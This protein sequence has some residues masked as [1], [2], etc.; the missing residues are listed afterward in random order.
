MAQPMFGSAAAS[1][2]VLDA[3][4]DVI[5]VTTTPYTYVCVLENLASGLAHVCQSAV[6]A[7]VLD[8]YAMAIMVV[9][10]LDTVLSEGCLCRNSSSCL[11]R[12]DTNMVP[13]QHG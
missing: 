4:V 9:M 2:A 10:N 7:T 3:C 8:Y 6:S 12:L 1:A 13:H 5:S 11:C